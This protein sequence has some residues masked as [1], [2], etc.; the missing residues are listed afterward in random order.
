MAVGGLGNREQVLDR[1]A[2]DAEGAARPGHVR[3]REAELARPA[4]K[5]LDGV[6]E[7]LEPRE[8]VEEVV[9]LLRV[10]ELLAL[11]RLQV[12]RLQP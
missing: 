9:E 5:V 4:G 12:D 8:R 1:T 6:I 3:D 11:A 10:A 2:G 7:V